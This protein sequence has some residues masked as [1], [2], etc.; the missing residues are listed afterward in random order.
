VEAVPSPCNLVCTLDRLDI[1]LG[2][3]RPIAEIA[4]WSA[5]ADARRL[6]IVTAA[7]ARLKERLSSANDPSPS[8]SPQT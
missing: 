2:C 4:E 1:C 6:A 3:G 8:P 5:A 7:S